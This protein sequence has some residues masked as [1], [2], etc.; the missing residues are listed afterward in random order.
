[1]LKPGSSHDRATDFLIA[2]LNHF[3]ESLWRNED[4]G[5]KR[6]NFL[7]TWVTAVIA[8]IVALHT[9]G[10]KIGKFTLLSITNGALAG[11]FIL[12]LLTYMRM[13][14]RNRVTDQYQRTLKYIRNQLLILN[15]SLTEYSVPQPLRAGG[16]KWFRGGL[17][18]TVGAID[19]VLL[20]VLLILNGLNV[21]LANTVSLLLFAVLWTFASPRKGIS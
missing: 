8:G 20:Y 15:P 13:L 21:W 9:H 10:E 14:Q 16:W 3:G 6:F 7:I 1:M 5:E 17:A 12:G 18:E 4:V 2:D 19:A 11:I